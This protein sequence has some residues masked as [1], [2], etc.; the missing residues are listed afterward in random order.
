M[1][2]LIPDSV[3]FVKITIEYKSKVYN[4][5]LKSFTLNNLQC[6]SYYESYQ[7][8]NITSKWKLALQDE[9]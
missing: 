5:T 7:I 1:C 9:A 4:L 6:I 2:Q 3:M 8:L